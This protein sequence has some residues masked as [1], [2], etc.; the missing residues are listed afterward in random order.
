M[1]LLATL[2]LCRLDIQINLSAAREFVKDICTNPTI[3]SKESVELIAGAMEIRSGLLGFYLCF[4]KK[5]HLETG[6]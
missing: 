1:K 3:E 6:R 4:P 2:S 5:Q